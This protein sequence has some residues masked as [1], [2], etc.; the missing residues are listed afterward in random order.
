M[1]EAEDFAER[2]VDALAHLTVGLSLS[3][4]A[5]LLAALDGF[6]VTGVATPQQVE[7][8]CRALE[9]TGG[10][11]YQS[12]PRLGW[13]VTDFPGWPCEVVAAHVFNDYRAGVSGWDFWRVRRM[14]D[15]WR[16]RLALSLPG[17]KMA[18]LLLAGFGPDGLVNTVVEMPVALTPTGAVPAFKAGAVRFHNGAAPSG[19]S[20][21]KAMRAVYTDRIR[22]AALCRLHEEVEWSVLLGEPGLPRARF[23]TDPVG[24]RE[25]FRLRDVPP[26]KARRAALRHWVSEHWRKKG[27]DS[28]ADRA[29]VREHLRGAEDF[30]WNGLRCRIEPSREDLRRNR[31]AA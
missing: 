9:A 2:V 29:W 19:P 30:T 24:V 1:S 13:N 26:G 5:S 23:L 3:R 4:D 14:P 20:I 12:P 8:E 16:G 17:D 7:A 6:H 11:P 21:T 25:A 15:H 27:R 22:M 10:D 31:E 28:E 18:E